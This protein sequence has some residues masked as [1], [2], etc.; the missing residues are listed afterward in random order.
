M[1]KRRTGVRQAYDRDIKQL[2]ANARHLRDHPEH[3]APSC[4]GRCPL[5]CMFKRARKGIKRRH[6]M[7][8]DEDKLERWG[9]WG[10][11]YAKAYAT[12]LRVAL[13]DED[14]LEYLQNVSTHKGRVPIVPWGQAPALANVGLQHRHDASLRLL[15]A[16]PFVKEGDAVFAT[17]ES[18]VCAHDG[19]LPE[20]AQEA[21]FDALPVEKRSESLASCPHG[22]DPS[23]ED[24]FVE[25]VWNEGDLRLRVCEACASGNLLARMQSV[26][27]AK[28]VRSLVDIRMGLDRLE[29]PEGEPWEVSWSLP[30]AVVEAYAGAEMGDASLIEE[31]RRAR[32]F[33]VEARGE[34][35]IV[36]GGVVYP[37]PFDEVLE[38]LGAEGVEAALIEAALEELDRPVVLEKGTAIELLEKVWAEQGPRAL[39]EVL[40]EEAVEEL[41]DPGAGRDAL[42]RLV[43][44]V[45]DRLDA[46]RVEAALPEYASLPAP[47]D[48]ADE[49]ARAMMR[50]GRSRA[51]QRL[52]QTPTSEQ[53]AVAVALVRALGLPRPAWTVAPRTE[54]MAEHLV[55]YAEDLLEAEGEAYHEALVALLKATGSTVE[56]ERMD[57]PGASE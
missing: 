53:E 43:S 50:E 41:F 44:V 42:E 31:A 27:V 3:A 39:R 5:F 34:A 35:V 18:M 57:E 36:W 46:R 32:G 54:D 17:G 47:V 29:T 14:R 11:D 55:P 28:D 25:V 51:Q 37:A 10:N 52:N 49:V 19:R 8:E 38:G 20:E 24:V 22:I 1:A 16:V 2:Q 56:I 33:A 30:E 13:A 6:G 23:E 9:R 15:A 48:L 26:M 12:V 40:D 7:R 21:F 4:Q 45:S